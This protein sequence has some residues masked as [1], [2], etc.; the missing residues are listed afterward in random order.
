MDNLYE[1]NPK[2]YWNLLDQLKN[3]DQ[4]LSKDTNIN[5]GDWKHYFEDLNSNKKDPTDIQIEE[6]LSEIEKTVIFNELD[7]IISDA[8]IT[9]AIKS[10]K[11]SKSSGLSLILNEMLKYGQVTLKPLLNKLF[12]LV[13]SNSIYPVIWSQGYIAPLYKS[14]SVYDP[15]NYRGI[16]ISDNIGKLFNRILN[17][18]LHV[19]KFMEKHNIIK[20]EQIGFIKGCR[21]TDH[22]FTLQ[23]LIQKYNKTN[24]KPLYACFV[25][26][27]RAFD[28]VLHA[29]LL[30][31]LKNTGVGNKFYDIIKSMYCNTEI[32]VKSDNFR[33]EFFRSTLGVRQGDNLSPN[34]FNLYINDLPNY[35]D[36][37]CDPVFL[38]GG[39]FNCLMY[40]DDVVLLSTSEHGLQNCVNKLSKFSKDWKMSIN[41]KKTKVLVFTKSGRQKNLHIKYNE[42]DIEN[43]KQYT[44]LGV[45][46]TS[47]GSFGAAK[48]E[49]FKKGMKA[50]FKFRKTFTPDTPGVKTLLHVFNH[51]VRP[52]LNYGSEIWGIFSKNKFE[53]DKDNFLN[54]QT[55]KLSVEKVHTKFCKF[56]LGVRTKSSDDACRGELGSYPILYDVLI[57]MIKYWCYMIKNKDQPSLLSD[58]FREN[59]HAE[60]TNQ[61]CWL[62][63]IKSLFKYLNLQHLYKNIYKLKDT[64][65]IN[66]VKYNLKEKF[67]KL[68]IDK[69]FNDNRKNLT[70]KNKLRT[71]RKF[72]NLFK[73]EPY[74]LILNKIERHALSKFRISSHTLEIERGRYLGIKAKERICKLCQK[75]TEDEEHFM[76]NCQ[77]LNKIRDCFFQQISTINK[78]FT[79]LN[80]EQKLVW[81]LSSEDKTI[82]S[83]IGKLIISLF[84]K[85]SILLSEGVAPPVP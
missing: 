55:N 83:N 85:R 37:S 38:N 84:E 22:M 51:T 68:W 82:I 41:T 56:V 20:K 66:K 72:K 64:F 9:K 17:N 31:K 80:N 67:K 14:G 77:K 12:N 69:L 54:I 3:A 27:K 40:A 15:A 5:L 11:N 61:E 71:Y 52:V 50:L 53:K 19:I 48:T 24:S 16:T 32:C 62:S 49:I 34:L 70:Q 23:T 81:L 10:L 47:S 26:F 36:K 39:N 29:G 60:A 58:S 57:N 13:F 8:E 63:C 33:S 4:K 45:V 30:Y 35:F 74:L 21:T 75:E 43:V 25:D 79:L 2:E 18:R 6:K 7:F 65:V 73:L 46:F 42:I 28:S 59:L 44:Y 76:I 78:N 1:N